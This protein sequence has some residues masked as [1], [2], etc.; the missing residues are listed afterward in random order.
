MLKSSAAVASL[1]AAAAALLLASVLLFHPAA[2]FVGPSGLPCLAVTSASST[3]S[4]R[5][6]KQSLD[7]GDRRAAALGQFGVLCA[8]AWLA[9]AVPGPAQ[10]AKKITNLEE[11]RAL[12]EKRMEE[13]ERSKGPLIKV[14]DGAFEQCK[15]LADRRVC[16]RL[17][18]SFISAGL[19]F[20]TCAAQSLHSGTIVNQHH[21]DSLSSG[22][23]ID[24]PTP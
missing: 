22:A 5:M 14:R 4:L 19:L 7:S 12:G 3:T 9:L 21:K 6:A 15:F 23:T 2:A 8:G 16:A 18:S 17:S 24:R 1:A 11:A 10:A 20:R 13:I